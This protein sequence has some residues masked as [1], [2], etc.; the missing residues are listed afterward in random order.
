MNFHAIK[1]IYQFEMARL[2]RT[3]L[4]SVVSP[5][6]STSLFFVV[7]G[8]AIVDTLHNQGSGKALELVAELASGIRHHKS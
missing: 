3:A 8:S 1:A 4:Q 5:V 2:R 7:V 6:V